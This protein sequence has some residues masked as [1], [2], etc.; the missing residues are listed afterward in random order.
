MGLA[1]RVLEVRINLLRFRFMVLKVRIQG[2][3]FRVSGFKV[4]EVRV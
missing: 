1:F 4:F 3:V 2:L